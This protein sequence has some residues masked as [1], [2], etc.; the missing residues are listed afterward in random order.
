M[1]KRLHSLLRT[2]AV[3]LLMASCRCLAA[4]AGAH[5]QGR[6]A[7]IAGFAN[8]PNDARP[9]VWWHWM[10]GNV[11]EAG[12]RMDLAWMHRVGLGGLQNFDAAL[13]TPRV[14]KRRLIYMHS[15][16][17]RAFRLSATLANKYRF[18]FGIAAAPGWSETG[19][20][21]VRPPDGMK[22]L[23]WSITDVRG[24]EP[25]R[26]QLAAP[27]SKSGPFQ[28]IG[29]QPDATSNLSN[30]VPN[31]SPEFYGDVAVLAIPA[32]PTDSLPK[33]EISSSSPLNS[34][35]VQQGEFDLPLTNGGGVVTI[36][37]ESPQTIRSATVYIPSVSNMFFGALVE[38]RLEAKE[39]GDWHPL[40]NIALSNVPSTVGF[41]PARAQEFRLVIVPQVPKL[42]SHVI[43]AKGGVLNAE[44]LLDIPKS[45]HI[46]QLELSSESRVNQFEMKAGF[47]TTQDYYALERQDGGGGI[48]LDS[49][50]NLTSELQPNGT[51]DWTPPPGRWRVLRLGYSLTGATNHPATREA[52]GLE[53]DKFD[54]DAVDRYLDKYFRIYEAFIGPALMGRHGVQSVITDSIES[55]SNWTPNIIQQ[56][57]RL[58]GYD[59][60]PWLPALT[61]VVMVDQASSDRFLYDFRR[62]LAELIA[63]QHY[64]RVAAAAHRRH[65]NY[66]SEA[67]EY[68]RPSLG[69]DIAMRAS[70]DVPM[71]ALWTFPP[72]SQSPSAFIADMKGASSTAHLYGKKVAAAETFTSVLQ[73]W[74]YGPSD[75]KAMLDVEF[76]SG[77]NRPVIHTSVHQPV[78]GKVP[79]LTLS[80]YG[81]NFTRNETWAEMARPWIDYIAR[82]SYLLQQGA[83]IADVAYF[84]GEEAPLTALFRDAPV[85]DAP[86]RYAYDFVSADALL[87]D[88]SVKNRELVSRGGARY[89]ILYLGGTSAR[90]TVPVLRRLNEFVAEGAMLV[91]VAPL[92]S[93]S[94]ADSPAE[95]KQL[96]SNLWGSGR[97]NTPV[98]GK[99]IATG[100]VENA[101]AQLGIQPDFAP[102]GDVTD[103]SVQFVHRKSG[104]ADIYF[105]A[106]RADRPAKIAARFRVIGK[107]PQSWDA[108]TGQVKAISYRF[109]KGDTVVPLDIAAHDS[110]FLVFR[111]PAR[112]PS[113]SVTKGVWSTALTVRG[114]WHVTFQPGRGARGPTTLASLAPLNDSS[115]SGVKYFSGVATYRTLF[116]LPE[117]LAREKP[118][119]LDLGKVADVAKVYVN[120]TLVGTAWK[121]P[122]RL[123]VSKRVRPGTNTLKIQIADLWV[124]R[125]IGDQQ[126][127]AKKITFT[128]IPTYT[129][130]APLRPSGLI[131]PVKLLRSQ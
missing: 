26:G 103:S 97:T 126:P 16:W 21:W 1:T 89:K 66:Y 64:A 3:V 11:S 96:V 123:D 22:K 130:D 6:D 100:D 54:G 95:F 101:L 115:D 38:A 59:P 74:E 48:P 46:A 40:T 51:I 55:I 73:P 105:L 113:L 43:A 82:S 27:P 50:I 14:V 109:E 110:L 85:K 79:G 68:G 121:E 4:A 102:L 69:D 63:S 15:G 57:R 24:G 107:A 47:A 12:I 86:Q 5:A 9:L 23:V 116:R 87:H 28:A 42:P 20:P 117:S 49:V 33:L 19:G 127:G 93:P 29:L 53:V 125:L 94:E 81:I 106:N 31:P 131:G 84:Y 60:I 91:G 128:T 56:F 114:P 111:S 44:G 129:R 65:M 88:L 112:A 124:N 78:Q 45:V 83:N 90:M 25:F 2:R 75:L 122:F 32:P 71:G 67:L 35:A 41:A 108:A 76:L 58:R 34:T 119:I 77:I 13:S 10:N 17:K 104:A 99:V 30:D 7:L 39:S 120:S 72:G 37:Y 118:L 61:G 18:E 70:A 62:T 36:L 92:S 80:I 52:T 8:P 98:A